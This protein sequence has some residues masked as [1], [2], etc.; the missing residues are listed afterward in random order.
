MKLSIH[1]P[2]ATKY[3]S[4]QETGAPTALAELEGDFTT[5][6]FVS[7]DSSMDQAFSEILAVMDRASASTPDSFRVDDAQ[8]AYLLSTVWPEA[9]VLIDT[10]GE[11]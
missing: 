9:T 3:D 7:P 11:G 1:T 8:M 2:T 5:T 4:D 6:V 10:P